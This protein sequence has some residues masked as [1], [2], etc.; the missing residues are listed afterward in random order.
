MKL[1]IAVT[2]IQ[3]ALAQL[4]AIGEAARYFADHPV[5]IGPTVFYGLY[6]EVRVGYMAKAASEVAPSIPPVIAQTLPRGATGMAVALEKLARDIQTR[7][8]S[9]APVRTGALRGSIGVFPGQA[10]SSSGRGGT[11]SARMRNLPSR[12]T[13][14]RRR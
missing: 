8:M 13:G 12:R 3:P 4:G 11:P 5:S 10:I 6:Q 7:G 1:T 9:G 14:G 2:G